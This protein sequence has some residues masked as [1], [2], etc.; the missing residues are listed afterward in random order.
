[1]IL[2]VILF[3]ILLFTFWSTS[4]F[5][6]TNNKIFSKLLGSRVQTDKNIIAQLLKAEPGKKIFADSDNDGKN[7][8][9]YM[10]DTDKRHEDKFKPILVKIVDE[11]GDMH[12]TGEGD[13]D[14]DLYIADW[15]ADGIVDRIIDYVDLDHDND[16][17]EQVQYFWSDST[18]TSKYRRVWYRPNLPKIY[19]GKNYFICWARDVGDDNRLWWQI[20][21]DYV[22]TLTQWN[23]DYNGDETLVNKF[24]YDYKEDKIIPFGEIKFSFYDLDD[25]KYSE[26]ALRFGGKSLNLD[27]LRYS[28]DIDNDV[29]ITSVH[30]YDFS[31]TCVGPIVIPE[32]KT[33]KVKIRNYTTEPVVQWKYMREVAEAGK[34]KKAHLTWDENDN[35]IADPVLSRID[36]VCN[37]RWEGVI[38]HQSEFMKRVGGPSCGIY[39]KRNEVDMDYSGKMQFYYS[40]VDQRLHL[41]GAEV[42]WI[43]VD[44]NYDHKVDMFV[45]ME[46]NDKDGF[47]DTWKYDVNGDCLGKEHDKLRYGSV[48]KY[49]VE[50]DEL[51]ERV[52]HVKDDD[53]QII[54]FDYWTIH[55]R[56]IS[57]LSRITK[58]NQDIITIIKKLLSNY[59]QNFEIGP[60]E[61]Y[62]N[63][64]LVN[65]RKD[66]QIGEKIKKSIEGK[67]YYNDVIRERYWDRLVNSSFK[68]NPYYKEINDSY[69]KGSFEHT[70]GL[71]KSKV[72]QKINNNR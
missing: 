1:M 33:V 26:A 25:D 43:K 60:V 31:I 56:Y 11:D 35:N 32:E 5:A 63:S 71:L 66:Y 65:Y 69:N 44:Y 40:P 72:L 30:D 68:D 70:A 34:W 20:N 18:V 53:M 13:L 49:E 67:R 51:Y 48:W 55:N 14:S 28:Y 38:N 64:S 50:G 58:A 16:Q 23:S 47:F 41:Y 36:S 10:I 6:Q 21:Y 4:L 39:N 24:F 8:I 27:N 42:G 57:S 22:Q 52:V 7:D 17:D 61:C 37:E 45:W 2:R 29:G 59:E 12:L 19:P 54:P 9:L 62:F 46:D 15:Y 3:N